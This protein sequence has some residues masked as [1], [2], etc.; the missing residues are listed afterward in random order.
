MRHGLAGRFTLVQSDVEAV[1]RQ[2]VGEC[3]PHSGHE[4]PHV[5]LDSGSELEERP[6]MVPGDDERVTS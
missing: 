3:R 4:P 2:L 1:G 5:G 6:G